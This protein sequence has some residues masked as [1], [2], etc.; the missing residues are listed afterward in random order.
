MWITGRAKNFPSASSD[1]ESKNQISNNIYAN[2]ILG[3]TATLMMPENLM[4]ER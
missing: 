3:Y 2:L 1:W 4:L